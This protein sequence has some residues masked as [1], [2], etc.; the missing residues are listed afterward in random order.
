[1]SGPSDADQEVARL[2]EALRQTVREAGLSEREVERRI[3]SAQDL[4]VQEVFDVLREA[5]V[6]PKD[7]FRSPLVSERFSLASS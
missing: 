1:M 5:G 7:F 4:T 6:A 2:C 3:G